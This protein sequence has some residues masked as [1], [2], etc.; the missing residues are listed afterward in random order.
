MRASPVSYGNILAVQQHNER[1][2]A[3]G[4]TASST[5]GESGCERTNHTDGPLPTKPHD[6]ASIPVLNLFLPC[7]S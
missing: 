5:P 4:Y 6:A 2:F 1:V 3:F 7:C